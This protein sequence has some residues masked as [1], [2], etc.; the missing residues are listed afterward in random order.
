[1]YIKIR[2]E[3]QQQQNIIRISPVSENIKMKTKDFFFYLGSFKTIS[4]TSSHLV[5]ILIGQSK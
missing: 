2:P 5:I 4:H 1:M 3:K